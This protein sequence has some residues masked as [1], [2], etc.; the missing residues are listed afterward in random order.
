[1]HCTEAPEPDQPSWPAQRG[2]H[3]G[4]TGIGYLLAMGIVLPLLF[5]VAQYSLWYNA[6]SALLAAAQT[7]VGMDRASAGAG[8]ISSGTSVAEQAGL[9]NV[10]LRETQTAT[11]ITVTATGDAD[12]MINVPGL[13]T[14]TE[15][16]TAPIETFR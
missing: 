4:S 6:K 9:R 5:T 1:M 7:T 15:S 2:E 16:V 11:T 8:G 12:Y 3:G 10:N 13:R 14:I